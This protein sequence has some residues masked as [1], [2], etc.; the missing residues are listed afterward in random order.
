MQVVVATESRFHSGDGRVHAAE[1]ASAYHFWAGYLEV[2][3][4]VVVVGRVAPSQRTANG[5]ESVG[6]H[7]PT[8]DLL[9]DGDGVRFVRLPAYRGL[10]GYL[11][12][13]PRIRRIIRSDVLGPR[14][15]YI[16]RMP[17]L[18]GAAL[19]T[20]LRRQKVGY[21]LEVVGDPAEVL[22]RDPGGA[23]TSW[24][25]RRMLARDCYHAAAVSYVTSKVLQRRY[26]ARPGVPTASYSCARLDAADF[27]ATARRPVAVP[28]PAR[29]LTIGSQ[30]RD[31][32]GHDVLLEA[33][34]QVL[35]AG[36]PVAVTIVG[37]GR[38]HGHLVAHAHRLGITRAVT[39]VRLLASRLEVR[40][41]LDA[42]DLFVL[43][44]RTE[45]LPRVL[46]EASARGLP[47]IGS[48]VG[49][50]VELLADED[51]VPAGEP[52][53]LARQISTMITDPRRLA[54]AS[55]RNLSTAQA[56]TSDRL[57]PRALDYY[58]R[59]RDLAAVEPGR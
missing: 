27:V 44:S 24:A 7:A 18:V 29:I 4:H 21:A 5:R 2:F 45:G 51:L 12:A 14:S 20:E 36:M 59:V 33:T 16:A 13:L 40:A 47:A 58:R 22:A 10:A 37:D 28:S 15:T 19:T 25:A 43:P 11:S 46:V 52:T 35:A 57:R 6:N 41:A 8:G 54:A 34:A 49:G 31:Y 26:P 50:I 56:F 3:D 39:F 55:A 30:E 9:A 23:L 38:L 48:A 32:K 53:R 1:P 42:T 17:G